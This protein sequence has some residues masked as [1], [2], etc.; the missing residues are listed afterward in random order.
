MKTLLALTL[1]LSACANVGNPNLRNDANY[2]TVHFAGAQP[3]QAEVDRCAN[4]ARP[5]FRTAN[6]DTMGRG[7][8]GAAYASGTAY[9]KCMVRAGYTPK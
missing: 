8:S 5:L 6:L 2:H 7:V 4:E 3:T 9:E 1:L